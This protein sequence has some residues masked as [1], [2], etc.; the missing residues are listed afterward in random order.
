MGA[1]T[2][3]GARQ[4]RLLLCFR[5]SKAPI[6]I[7]L[8]CLQKGGPGRERGIFSGFTGKQGGFSNPINSLLT[9]ERLK[10]INLFANP[11]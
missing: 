3:A 11:L 7:P 5:V 10:Q 8:C 9:S 1:S 6:S 2:Q 4:G